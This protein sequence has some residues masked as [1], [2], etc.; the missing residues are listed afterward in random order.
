MTIAIKNKVLKEM[1]FQNENEL[2]GHLERCPYLLISDS[3]PRVKSVQREVHLPSAGILD[4]LLVDETGC[5]IAV[6]VKLNRNGQSRREVVAQ[7]FDYVSDLSQITVDELDGI[8]NGAL[9]QAIS[10]MTSDINLWKQCGVYLRAGLIKVVIAVDKANEDLRRIVQYINEHSDLDVRL[11]SISKYDNGEILV[12]NII[13]AGAAN[14]S[15]A[16]LKKE[17]IPNNPLFEAVIATYNQSASEELATRGRART[18]RQVRFDH[19]P[20]AIHYEF[21][22]YKDSNEITVELHLEGDEVKH[23]GPS[24]KSFSGDEI[25]GQNIEWDEKW[26]KQRGR[27]RIRYSSDSPPELIASAMDKLVEKTFESVNNKLT[28]PPTLAGVANVPAS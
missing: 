26:N 15:R 4:L 6:E 27:I 22:D 2:Q 5:P 1:E 10:E 9:E 28:N 23:L 16:R 25:S 21:L 19:W 8:V 13:V 17:S 18:F 7:A 11:V 14:S 20:S 3:E 12:P 24:L